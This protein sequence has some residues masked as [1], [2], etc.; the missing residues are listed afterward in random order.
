LFTGPVGRCYHE[1]WVA[2]CLKNLKSMTMRNECEKKMGKLRLVVFDVDGTLIKVDSSWSFLHKKLGTWNQGKHYAEL[3]F[4]GK[5]TYEEW[6]QLDASLW[7]NQ[8]LRKVQQI[9][10]EI[11]YVDGAQ[12]VIRTL[13]KH[14]VA[15]ALLSAGLSLL[16]KKIESELK[17]DYSLSNELIVRS[18]FLTGEV[19]V[20]V[21]LNNKDEVLS[22]IL[23][24]FDIKLNE[25]CA[26]GDDESLIP[27][28][29]K[30]ALG[31]A[32]NP[33]S[34]EVEKNADVIVKSGDLRD[35]L[36]HVLK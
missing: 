18:D 10:N 31:I 4:Q 3:F 22:H 28:F 14:N 12:E 30:V 36:P 20:N 25:C 35:I 24:M 13:K 34:E 9:V 16:S 8:P 7:K 27:L 11:P 23:H 32:F 17:T 33:C 5:I 21:S 6:A 26:V 29:K 15:V 2:V 1:I 19:K